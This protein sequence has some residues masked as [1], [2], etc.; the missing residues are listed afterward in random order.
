MFNSSTLNSL[1]V[2]RD[3]IIVIALIYLEP[4]N[5]VQIDLLVRNT[6]NPLAVRKN[7]TMGFDCVQIKE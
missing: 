4:F 2:S 3:W 6:W 1:N 7:W 5:C